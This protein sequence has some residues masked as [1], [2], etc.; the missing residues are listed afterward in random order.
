MGIFYIE[1]HRVGDTWIDGFCR[2]LPKH[3][4]L[5]PDERQKISNDGSR[6]L[7]RIQGY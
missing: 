6:T 3:R 7:R 2:R 4:F 1:A 5:D